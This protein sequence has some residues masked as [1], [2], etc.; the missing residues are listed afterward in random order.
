MFCQQPVIT[1]SSGSRDNGCRPLQRWQPV[2]AKTLHTNRRC[3]R[4]EVSSGLRESVVKP[5]MN[6]LWP[7]W[8]STAHFV[9]VSGK[10]SWRQFR[11]LLVAILPHE[12]RSRSTSAGRGLLQWTTTTKFINIITLDVQRQSW[13]AGEIVI[14]L[15]YRVTSIEGSY[16]HVSNW[17]QRPFI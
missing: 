14:F 15:E 2:H 12:P 10:S 7:W 6:W 3:M 4:T 9:V 1:M 17:T 5:H 8:S 13:N 11:C 16:F